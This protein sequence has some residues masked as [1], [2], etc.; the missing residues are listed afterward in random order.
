MSQFEKKVSIVTGAN[1][2]IG[3]A[4]A[5]LLAQRGSKVVVAARREAEGLAVVKEITDAGGQAIFVRTDVAVESDVQNLVQQTLAT[6][7]QIDVAF[8]NSGVFRPAPI[9]D[10]TADDL[11]NQIDVNVKGVYYVIK[12]LVPAFGEKGGSIVVNSSVVADVGFAGLTA[13]SLTKGAVNTLVRGAAVEL[14]G[15]NIRVNAVAPGPIWTEGAE[16]MAGSKD[17]FEQMM[18]PAVA[19]ARVG[20]PEEVAEA[21]AFLASD[22]AS[23]ITGQILAVDGGVSVK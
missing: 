13:Y 15:R 20:R 16:A 1:S 10:Q 12:H 9:T 14:A 3:R 2:G 23:F 18:I 6:Y 4:T 8:L 7:G 22:A 21:A 19:L 5:K 17:N 11:G